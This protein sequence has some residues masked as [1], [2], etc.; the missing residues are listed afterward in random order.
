MSIEERYDQPVWFPCWSPW[1][2]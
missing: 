1:A 2:H